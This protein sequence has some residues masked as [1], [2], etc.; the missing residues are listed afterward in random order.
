MN[1]TTSAV[2]RA[3]LGDPEALSELYHVHAGGLL[4]VAY[5]LLGSRADA[6]DVVHDVFV[7]LPEA[8]AAYREQGRFAGW[9]HRLTVRTALQRLRRT[10]REEPLELSPEQEAHEVTAHL[11]DWLERGIRS[12][13]ET[14]RVV[15]VLKEVEG[16]SH[17]EIAQLL[18]IRKGTSEVRHH[19]A[20]KQL[21]DTLKESV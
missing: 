19:R 11:S 21:R 6:E 9:L 12:L 10:R 13:P 17:G 15:F 20:I 1:S 18:G 14:L 16:Y 2:E 8:L 4:R 5:H 7:G 3:R